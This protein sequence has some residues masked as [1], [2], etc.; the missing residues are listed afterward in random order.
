MTFF[1]RICILNTLFRIMTVMIIFSVFKQKQQSGKYYTLILPD[2]AQARHGI[3]FQGGRAAISEWWLHHDCDFQ[4]FEV[5]RPVVSFVA[6]TDDMVGGYGKRSQSIGIRDRF[7]SSVERKHRTYR[8]SNQGWI[9]LSS[10]SNFVSENF[11]TYG[12]IST[13][14]VDQAMQQLNSTL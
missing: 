1:P 11:S 13:R 5:I 6:Q 2:G 4:V 14:L 12:E 8:P 7:S 10:R 3:F 9:S